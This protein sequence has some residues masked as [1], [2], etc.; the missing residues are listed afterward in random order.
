MCVLIMSNTFIAESSVVAGVTVT[1][2]GARQV[3]TGAVHTLVIC[4]ISTFIDICQNGIL[5]HFRYTELPSKILISTHT[6]LCVS[7]KL[8]LH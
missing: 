6:I 5:V 8:L 2:V 7:T 3:D 1:A 4:R